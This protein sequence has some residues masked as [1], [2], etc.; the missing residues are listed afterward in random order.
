MHDHAVLLQFILNLRKQVN[1]YDAVDIS[2]LGV[3][4]R[5]TTL[6]KRQMMLVTIHDRIPISKF[7]PTKSYLY[8]MLGKPHHRYKYL[9]TVPSGGRVDARPRAHPVKRQQAS[10]YLYYSLLFELDNLVKC[11]Y[12]QI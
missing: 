12:W 11:N 4:P 8:I 2:M 7:H 9:F 6:A 1:P 10:F 3:A 5:I